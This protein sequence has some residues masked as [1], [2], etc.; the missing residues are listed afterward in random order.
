M[1]DTNKD[2]DFYLQ[3]ASYTHPS[4]KKKIKKKNNFFLK[5]KKWRMQCHYFFIFTDLK[6]H[7]KNTKHQANDKFPIYHYLT[8]W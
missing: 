4:Q 1:G 3:K 7:Y 5:K 8:Y 6:D 2:I